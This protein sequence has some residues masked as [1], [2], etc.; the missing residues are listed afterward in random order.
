MIQTI[1][2]KNTRSVTFNCVSFV[3]QVK[4]G[5][6]LRHAIYGAN[7]KGLASAPRALIS[8][9]GL[10][11]PPSNFNTD[12]YRLEAFGRLFTVDQNDPT[13]LMF[14]AA[15]SLNDLESETSGVINVNPELGDILNIRILDQSRILIVQERGFYTLL[16]THDPAGFVLATLARSFQP[17]VQNTTQVFG[18]EIYYLTKGGGMCRVLRNGRVQ[19]LDIP[20][21]CQQTK[22]DSTVFQNR[23]YLVLDGKLLVIERFF[24]GFSFIDTDSPPIRFWESEPFGLSYAANRQWLKQ[25]LIKTNCTLTVTLTATSTGRTQVLEIQAADDLQRFNVNLRGDMFTIRLD[26]Q[27]Q[28]ENIVIS[29]LSAV[30]A[31]G[32]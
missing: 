1:P 25:L 3:P 9:K 6:R 24:E 11:A 5:S 8:G 12:P 18:D 28:C 27:R 15:M 16:V 7:A 20:I 21:D 17:I 22:Y 2:F 23:Y 29:D 32:N 4:R 10:T 13:C 14:S 19:Q 30:V 26:I 31:F